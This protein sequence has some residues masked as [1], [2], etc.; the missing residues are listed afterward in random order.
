MHVQE[1]LRRSLDAEVVPLGTN[2][3][4]VACGTD[5]SHSRGHHRRAELNRRA[6]RAGPGLTHDPRLDSRA[7]FARGHVRDQD[8]R[9]IQAGCRGALGRSHD[10]HL[11]GTSRPIGSPL[12]I[13][14]PSFSSESRSIGPKSYTGQ[15]GSPRARRNQRRWRLGSRAPDRK[16]HLGE[17]PLCI[18]HRC[19]HVVG[20]GRE[21]VLALGL[22][23]VVE[24]PTTD[25][26]LDLR[27]LRPQALAEVPCL[28]QASGGHRPDADECGAMQV[29]PGDYVGREPTAPAH[30]EPVQRRV[31]QMSTISSAKA[32]AS[33][34]AGHPTI[35]KR[36][37]AGA[38][39]E[40]G[41]SWARTSRIS[42]VACPTN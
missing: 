18:E 12:S 6:E 10:R 16:P 27:T 32:S 24:T 28:A 40:G 35:R 33:S 37:S 25:H 4:L 38:S 1:P 21:E 26:D 13:S 19:L 20:S 15:N 39:T 5:E 36:V 42:R 11:S 29:D 8:V 7:R 23:S 34:R 31:E 14:L 22:L 2:D 9:T 3:D 30:L 17:R 41:A